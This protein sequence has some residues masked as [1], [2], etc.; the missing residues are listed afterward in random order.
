V[1]VVAGSA[2]YTGA[3]VLA[4][5][6]ALRAGAGLVT[7]ASTA[8][9]R[10]AVA[11][12]LPEVTHLP[13]PEADDGIDATAGD[14]IVRALPAYSALLIGPGLGL[15]PGTQAMVRGVLT[16][17]AVASMPVVI[18]ADA[19]NALS[20][21][22]GWSNEVKAPA[23]LTPHPGEIARRL[24]NTAS[25]VQAS[26]VATATDAAANWR[27]TVVLK[28]AHSIVAQPGGEALISP[29]AT[30]VL[31][32]AGTGDVLAGAIAGLIAQGLEP[33]DAAG[34]GVY[35]H[36]AAGETF[37]SEYGHSGMLASELGPAIARVAHQ[38][39]RDE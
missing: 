14:A 18:D 5:I 31:A 33:Y 12:L 15:A 27:Q 34:L 2:N 28:G 36:G 4:S 23:V 35:L 19:L 26:R 38:L 20:R 24:G 22:P 30:A 9:V 29:H 6:G 39:R 16:A 21:M 17:P 32:T 13:L 11:A 8:P 1:L 7:L 3:A 37:S 10:A 25:D